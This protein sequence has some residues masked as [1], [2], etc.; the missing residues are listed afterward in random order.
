MWKRRARGKVTRLI[1][2]EKKEKKDERDAEP[3]EY[4]ISVWLAC[5]GTSRTRTMRGEML[6]VAWDAACS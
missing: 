4:C 3:A 6:A 2:R 1:E 5:S